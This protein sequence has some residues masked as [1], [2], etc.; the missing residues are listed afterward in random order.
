MRPSGEQHTI[1]HGAHRATVTEVGAS[2]R[3]YSVDGFDVI[4]GFGIDERSAA[5]RG[6]VLAPWPNRL[7]NGHYEFEGHAARV[8]LDEPELSN[9]IHGMVRWL[10]WQ[11]VSHSDEAVQLL[12]VLH[13]QPG[14]PWR[15]ELH[16]EYRLDD[17][18]LT[19]TADAT[20]AS[21]AV[22]PF[23]IG[24]HPYLTVGTP[25]VDTAWLVMP[26]RRRLLTDARGLPV[27]EVDLA[28]TEFDFA[29]RRPVGTVDLDTAY[30][31]LI[32]DEAGRACVQLDSPEGRSV[33]LWVDEAF[34]YLMA[35]TGDTLQPEGRRRKGIAIE[36]MT[37]PPNA[38]ASGTDL[39][40]LDRNQ[41]WLGRW[42]VRAASPR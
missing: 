6:Q 11:L 23:G 21:D 5:G 29:T 42:G 39:I 22:I 3:E 32:R 13:P 8:A 27:G 12:C 33:E 26:A 15:L 16:V 2:L 25:T 37:C 7:D 20:N 4:D 9:A 19:V 24:F 1:G 18:G 40:R 17:D 35:F 30:A 14:Y 38:L 41:S 10:P 36:P 31:D 28:G 34:R